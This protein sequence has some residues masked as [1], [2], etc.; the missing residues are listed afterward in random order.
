MQEPQRP[1]TVPPVACITTPRGIKNLGN[2]CFLNAPLQCLLVQNLPNEG[3][4]A[5]QAL[6]HHMK[7][8]VGVIRP[9]KVLQE[10]KKVCPRLVTGVQQDAVEAAQAIISLWRKPDDSIFTPARDALHGERLTMTR[11]SKCVYSTEVTDVMHTPVLQIA[12]KSDNLQGCIDAATST[13]IMDNNTCP[14]CGAIGT[15]SHCS[16][17]LILPDILLV[18]L[19]RFTN[20]GDKIL[21]SVRLQATVCISGVAYEVNGVVN[22]KGNLQQGHYTALVCANTQWY[23]CDDAVITTKAASHVFRS[24]NSDAYVVFLKRSQDGPSGG[25][26]GW[27]SLKGL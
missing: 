26:D 19:L 20:T 15:T 23:N 25:G 8:T 13:H 9:H 4:L 27:S 5:W 22:H 18:Q 7:A 10:I 1:L 11:C 3:N 21:A 16:Q 6:I 12:L 2:T 24:A 14:G 17:L